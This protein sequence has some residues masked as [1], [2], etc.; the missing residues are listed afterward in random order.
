MQSRFP[1]A[2]EPRQKA[3]LG[4]ALFALALAE[5]HSFTLAFPAQ[6]L[7]AVHEA[8]TWLPF[9]L[10]RFVPCAIAV[11]AGVILFARRRIAEAFGAHQDLLA[12]RWRGSALVHGSSVLLLFFFTEQLFATASSNQAPPVFAP[13][14]WFAF[15]AIAAVSLFAIALPLGAWCRLAWNRSVLFGATAGVLAWVVGHFGQAS[16]W[17]SFGVPT[18]VA[19]R[20]LL[21]LLM[22]NANVP[23]EGTLAGTDDFVVRIGFACSGYEGIGLVWIFL[24]VYLWVLRDRLEFPRAFWLLPIG[25]A[26]VW[27]ANVLRIVALILIGDLWSPALALGAFHTRMG[28]VLFCTI[29][30]GLVAFVERS[31][32]FLKQDQ[33]QHQKPRTAPSAVS[34]YLAPLFLVLAT[35][36]LVGAFVIDESSAYPASLIVGSLALW[37]YRHH[38]PKLAALWSWSG[39]AV[40]VLV[41]VVWVGLDTTA[42]DGTQALSVLDGPSATSPLL[43]AAFVLSTILLTPIAEELAFRGYLMR[44][45]ISA[46]TAEIP[47]GTYTLASTVLTATVFGAMHDRWFV[48]TL[49]GLA[50]GLLTCRTK[51]LAPAIQAHM[52]TNGLLVIWA[53]V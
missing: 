38:Y 21:Q 10:P 9:E 29:A 27:I 42:T 3:L 22:P 46:R 23:T 41:F 40:G 48:G 7:V 52:I 12:P 13:L 50:Y 14:L 15:A 30:L 24:C 20:F 32:F 49:A 51:S 4:L 11:F 5:A 44:R 45:F 17:E 39:T 18:L 34:A 25:T 28:W 19:V 36:L 2:G 6:R 8:W 35:Q 26:A 33:V 43:Y 37:H 1:I 53:L 47:L 16:F 31:N